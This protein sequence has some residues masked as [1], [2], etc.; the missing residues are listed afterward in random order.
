MEVEENGFLHG[1]EAIEH[2]FVKKQVFYFVFYVLS[3]N[4]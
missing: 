2:P 4:Y 1:T 3:I